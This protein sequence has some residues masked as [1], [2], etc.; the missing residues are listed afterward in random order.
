MCRI[1]LDDAVGDLLIGDDTSV[2]VC[3]CFSSVYVVDV[4]NSGFTSCITMAQEFN[5]FV[6][7]CFHHHE[8][9]ARY[10]MI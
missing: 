1:N 6:F 4:D 3:L 9:V 2:C 5:I 7:T 10:N 8:L